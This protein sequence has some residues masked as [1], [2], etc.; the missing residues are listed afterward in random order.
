MRFIDFFAGTGGIRRGLE[1]AGHKC[2]GFCEYDKFATAAYTSMHLLTDEQRS[3]LAT[4]SQRQIQHEVLNEEYRNGEWYASDIRNVLADELPRADMWCF[5][6]P[7]TSFS[8]AGKRA[9]LDGESG[10]IRE[11]FR[12]LGETR[13]ED[14]PEWLLY[15]NVKGM[16]SSNK[17][18][19]FLAI[20][21][22]MGDAGYDIEWQ[23]LN[24]KYF[25]AF[26]LKQLPE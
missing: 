7:C 8:V 13:E 16:F 5:G 12:L 10:L 26:L 14:R 2:V 18:L 6:A 19:D 20:L 22:E 24:S 15:E 4:L 3:Y 25:G 17:G 9:G 23:L 11:I 1:M 21:V